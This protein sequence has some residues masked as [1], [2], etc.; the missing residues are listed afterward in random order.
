MRKLP[1]LLTLVCIG[2]SACKILP[3]EPVKFESV[4]HLDPEVVRDSFNVAMPE[5]FEILDSSVF[6][7]YGRKFSALGATSIDLVNGNFTVAGLSPM[8][9]K[10]FEV[11]GTE[12]GE[13]I[14]AYFAPHVLKNP[15]SR[16]SFS[17]AIA[18]NIAH[19][20]MNRVPQK[21][22]RVRKESDQIVFQQDEEQGVL[23][24]IFAG[25][26]VLLVE[27]RF[28]RSGRIVWCVRYYEYKLRD[29]KWY[30]GG[31]VLRH[32]RPSYS[33]TLQLQEIF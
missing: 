23:E 20:Y 11:S 8:G 12:K 30:P 31:V 28:K 6:R 22:A 29:G 14:K 13:D 5:Q 21:D 18:S 26:D 16:Q 4:R 27:K 24:F 9:L 17:Q 3:F 7:I 33:L 15:D 1:V 2:L 25:K 10:L 32:F 19:I